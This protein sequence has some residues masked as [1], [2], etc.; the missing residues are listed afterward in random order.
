M[1]RFLNHDVRREQAELRE[2]RRVDYERVIAK[3]LA[4]IIAL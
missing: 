3:K 2:A 1:C 4:M